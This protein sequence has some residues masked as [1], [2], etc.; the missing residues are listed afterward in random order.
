MPESVPETSIQKISFVPWA[1][2]LADATAIA[3][4]V[5]MSRSSHVGTAH[6]LQAVHLPW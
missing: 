2:L 5:G 4:S 3:W 1:K 6:E